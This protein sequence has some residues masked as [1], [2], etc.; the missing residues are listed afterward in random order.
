MYVEDAV[1]ALRHREWNGWSFMLH[2]S[3]AAPCSGFWIVLC[4]PPKW[5]GALGKPVMAASLEDA[6]R[7]AVETADNWREREE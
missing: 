1:A 4:R 2:S 5:T 7:K 6:L 3:W